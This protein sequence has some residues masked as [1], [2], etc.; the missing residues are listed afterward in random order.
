MNGDDVPERF[1]GKAALARIDE[2]TKWICDT[3][4]KQGEVD[5][6]HELRIRN[7]EDRQ[8][9]QRGITR[10]QAMQSAGAG[11]ATGALAT[12]II[13]KIIALFGFGGA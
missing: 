5:V 12:A 13:M 3:L 4:K 11:G 7:L 10:G 9:E 8:S 6:D 2:R 1:D